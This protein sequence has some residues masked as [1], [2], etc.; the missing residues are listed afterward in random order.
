MHASAVL[1]VMTYGKWSDRFGGAD[2]PYEYVDLYDPHSGELFT[3]SLAESLQ[4]SKDRPAENSEAV[5]TF[6]LE[7]QAKPALTRIKKGEQAG[8]TIDYVAEKLKV[9]V[10]GLKTNTQQQQR[11]REVAKA[12]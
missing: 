12:A 10:L 11:P 6:S 8:Q 7:K 3:W 2:A 9:K 5:V 4:G 1:R